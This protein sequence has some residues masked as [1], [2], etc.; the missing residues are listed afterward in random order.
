MVARISCGKSIKSAVHYNEAKLADGKATLILSSRFGCNADDLTVRQKITR[1]E[2]LIFKNCKVKTNTVHISLNFPPGEQLSP[3][4]LQLLSAEYMERIGFGNQPFLVYQH[5]D[6]N[7]PHV[8]IVTTNIQGNGRAISLHNIA[9]AKSEPARKALELIYGLTPA[10]GRRQKVELKAAV[11]PATYG[12][13]ETKQ[14]ISN[15]VREVTSTFQYTNLAELNAILGHYN[16]TASRGKPGSLCWN[17]GGLVYSMIDRDGGKVGVPIQASDIYSKPVLHALERKM[18]KNRVTGIQKR[19][20]LWG[21]LEKVMASRSP[22]AARLLLQKCNVTY[23]PA[24]SDRDDAFLIDHRSRA[25]ISIKGEG[26]SPALVQHSLFANQAAPADS[27][28]AGYTT[29]IYSSPLSIS[30]ELLR[31]LTA[32]ANPHGEH[33]ASELLGRKRRRRRS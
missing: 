5:L 19:R 11:S 24:V 18:E 16:V 9:R 10:E 2:S 31:E 26:L 3:V 30:A 12:R 22:A 20:R 14:A 4:T 13:C 15:I 6:A 25:V 28:S 1:F 8:H 17:R 29:P 32:D 23:Q 33:L 21:I 27:L 7:H